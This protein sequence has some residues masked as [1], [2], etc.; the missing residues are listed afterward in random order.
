M[1][2]NLVAILIE[3]KID[4]IIFVNCD[5]NLQISRVMHRDQLSKS[6]VVSIVKSQLSLE[7]V[8]KLA[9]YILDGN[10]LEELYQQT[11]NLQKKL[12]ANKKNGF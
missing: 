4:K 3:L 8:H 2:H 6:Q 9:D 1:L 5:N 12:F 7:K 11:I 10:D